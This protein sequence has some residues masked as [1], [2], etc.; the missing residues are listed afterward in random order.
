MVATAQDTAEPRKGIPSFFCF[1][2]DVFIAAFV[3]S[4]RII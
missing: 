3:K 4:G 1:S 2:F